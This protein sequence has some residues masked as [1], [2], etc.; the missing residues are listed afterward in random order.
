LE[1]LSF[2]FIG[3]K[4][5]IT[6]LSFYRLPTYTMEDKI[7]AARAG[8]K[9]K[10]KRPR[11]II[12]SGK[13]GVGKTT[14]AAATAVRCAE[15]GLRTIAISIDIAHSLSDAFQLE[16]D[17]HDHNRGIYGR[18]CGSRKWTFKRNWIVTGAKCP[19]TWR[20]YSDP[21]A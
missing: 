10:D 8:G 3:V 1:D 14:V 21:V 16:V 20:R 5:P 19:N 12:F 2:D 15:I 13:G 17:L 11:I 7:V 6:P 9:L 18:T 4:S